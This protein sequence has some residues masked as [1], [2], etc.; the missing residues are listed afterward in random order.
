MGFKVLGLEFRAQG[1]EC[2]KPYARLLVAR[3]THPRFVVHS[4]LL[5]LE[6]LD[7]TKIQNTIT[8]NT[9]QMPRF[10]SALHRAEDKL[11]PKDAI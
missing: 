5:F 7:H 4:F 2:A 1:L 3:P 6:F 10:G 11:Y 8:G 9:I